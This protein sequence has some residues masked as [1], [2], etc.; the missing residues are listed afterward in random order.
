MA[1]SSQPPARNEKAEAAR[2]KA[3]A[4][5]RAEQRRTT[6]LWIVGAIAVVGLFAA[7]IA[8]IVRQD[9]VGSIDGENQLTPAVATADG[10][11][12][13]G[14]NGVVGK[15]L[16][17]ERVQLAVYLDFMCPVCGGFEEING[18]DIQAMSQEGLIDVVYH[19][20]S[21]LDRTSLGTAYSTRSA[22]AAAL[23][24][25]ESPE[26]FVAFLT[27]MFANQP[28]EGT[29]GL[30]DAEIQAIATDVGIPEA[31]VAKIPDYAYSQ[32]VTAATEKAS[33]AGVTGT[34]T[35]FINGEN[36]S[37]QGNPRAVNWSVPGNLRLA[38][39]EAAAE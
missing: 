36:R 12:P 5:V 26:L 21:F 11:F 31:T 19:P 39:E 6:V 8:F 9:A 7:L 30:N 15:D 18:A 4:Q 20:I 27:A 1:K 10:G 2:K 14:T 3:Q 17:P 34:P 37:G 24:A 35:I 29:R 28:E 25:E 22:S 33:V 16:D 13:V 23:V 38:V 32:W